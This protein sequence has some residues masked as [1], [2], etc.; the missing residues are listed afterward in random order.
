MLTDAHPAEFW[1]F[2]ISH[3]GGSYRA[4]SKVCKKG[5]REANGG[6]NLRGDENDERAALVRNA[7]EEV[8]SLY[9]DSGSAGLGLLRDGPCKVRLSFCAEH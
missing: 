8:V 7:L 3:R 9:S 4:L 1:A 5:G 6:N 2:L